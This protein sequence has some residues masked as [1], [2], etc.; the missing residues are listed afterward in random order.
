[1]EEELYGYINLYMGQRTLIGKPFSEGKEIFLTVHP[2]ADV[3]V[4]CGHHPEEA[5]K[6]H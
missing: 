5:A 1:M 4:Y 2:Q 6:Y 3:A